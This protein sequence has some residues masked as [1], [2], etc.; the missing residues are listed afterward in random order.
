MRF[1]TFTGRATS[2]QQQQ[3]EQP[4]VNPYDDN[5]SYVD[6]FSDEEGTDAPERQGKTKP[7]PMKGGRKITKSS[8][9]QMKTD[10]KQS[11]VV[12]QNWPA[13]QVG[14]SVDDHVYSALLH[15]GE[16]LQ[17]AT[18]QSP[19]GYQNPQDSQHGAT[20]DEPV[21][22]NVPHSD[23]GLQA[24]T[25]D[26]TAAY[27]NLP[28]REDV[29]RSVSNDSSSADSMKP[30]FEDD[31]DIDSDEELRKSMEELSRSIEDLEKAIV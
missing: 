11:T 4:E 18:E 19:A 17:A 24:A 31:D 28:A 3:T 25:K 29:A 12:Y 27:Q 15:T 5:D 2:Q 9:Q 10:T 21:Y 16:G 23:D 30:Q 8:K 7:T 6:S 22:H 13:R 14:A 26:S 1:S 20:V